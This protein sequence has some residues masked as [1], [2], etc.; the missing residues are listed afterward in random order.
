MSNKP[1]AKKPKSGE[2][3]ANRQEHERDLEEGQK[4]SLP[5]NRSR[6]PSW[7]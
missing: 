6:L 1:K 5:P 3:Q 2:R 7:L 4:L